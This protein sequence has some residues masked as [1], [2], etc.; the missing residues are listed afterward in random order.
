MRRPNLKTDYVFA[1]A[2]I[3]TLLIA[4]IY[5]T[6][7]LSVNNRFVCYVIIGCVSVLSILYRYM[8]Q[9]K[10][11]R[12]LLLAIVVMTGFSFALVPLYNVFCDVTGLNGKMDLTL[13]AAIPSGVDLTRTVIVEFVVNHNREMPWLFKPKHELLVL[14][15]GELAATAYY[16][17]NTTKRTMLAQA[18]PSISPSKASKYFKKIECF[19]FSRQKL[20][21][22]EV[23][24][25]NLRFYIDPKIPKDVQRLTLAYTI[26]DVTNSENTQEYK[27]G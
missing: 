6:D 24:H 9:Y 5:N 17:K 2:I 1:I 27:H 10:L 20:G 15:P 8:T 12:N 23:A 22:G 4:G 25:L 13:Q 3:G 11:I 18:I 7:L 26:F 21:P 16:A 14:H 19:C